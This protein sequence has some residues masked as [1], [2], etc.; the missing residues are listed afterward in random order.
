MTIISHP[1][2]QSQ[3]IHCYSAAVQPCLPGPQEHFFHLHFGPASL[4][5]HLIQPWPRSFTKTQIRITVIGWIT[6]SSFLNFK[7]TVKPSRRDQ[8]VTKICWIASHVIVSPPSLLTDN[9][10]FKLNISLPKLTHKTK[11]PTLNTAHLS[12][13]NIKTYYFYVT[14]PYLPIG[15]IRRKIFH[16]RYGNLYRTGARTN[17][18]PLWRGRPAASAAEVPSWSPCPNLRLYFPSAALFERFSQCQWAQY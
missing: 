7:R 9:H 5:R 15:L 10:N 13:Y 17:A 11:T 3:N 14:N 2:K 6:N 4:L 12:A 1:V 16:P 8:S 18:P